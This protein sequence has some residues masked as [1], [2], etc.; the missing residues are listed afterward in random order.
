VALHPLT[1][2]LKS[3]LRRW[4]MHAT[5]NFHF[6]TVS[7]VDLVMLNDCSKRKISRYAS[8][9]SSPI[10]PRLTQFL[11]T[12]GILPLG[13]GWALLMTP[14]MT[15]ALGLVFPVFF[16]H[17][18]SFGRIPSNPLRIFL[19]IFAL[20]SSIDCWTDGLIFADWNSASW[21]SANWISAVN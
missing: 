17:F 6:H 1:L 8:R 7:W 10:S 9:S 12:V 15:A 14:S 21:I 19:A 18:F 20:T 11:K 16:G 5:R 13:M 2:E 3:W 4:R